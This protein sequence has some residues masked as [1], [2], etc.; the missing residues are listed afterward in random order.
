MCNNINNNN[1]NNN[2]NNINNNINNI[3]NNI[4]LMVIL[5]K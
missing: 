4:I 1:I 2:I 3:N 5:M